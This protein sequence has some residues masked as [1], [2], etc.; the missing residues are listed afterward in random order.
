MNTVLLTSPF[1]VEIHLEN[2]ADSNILMIPDAFEGFSIGTFKLGSH[3]YKR[4]T[5]TL[6]EGTCKKCGKHDLLLPE[7]MLSHTCN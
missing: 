1:P 2:I 7:E 3:S 5:R 4:G 6:Y